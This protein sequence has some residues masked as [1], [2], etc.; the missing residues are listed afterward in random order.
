[1]YLGTPIS[2]DFDESFANKHNISTLIDSSLHW[3]QLDLETVLAELRSRELGGY[4]TSGKLNDWCISRQRYW[5]TPIPIIHCN[6]CGP[7]PVPMNELP[8]RLPSLENI[9]SSS[10]TGISPLANAHDWIKTQCPK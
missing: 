4:R 2:N 7:V 3:Y 1:N 8:I 10:K 5:G 9:K 6:H